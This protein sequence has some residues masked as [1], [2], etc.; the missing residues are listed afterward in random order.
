MPVDT[1]LVALSNTDTGTQR[2]LTAVDLAGQTN[3][4]V[5]LG[6][7]YD[8]ETHRVAGSELNVDSPDELAHRDEAVDA[9]ATTFADAGVTYEIR[10]VFGHDGEGF[11][12]LARQVD[13]DMV[14]VQGGDRT[15]V[16]KAVFGSVPQHILLHAPC[17]VLLVHT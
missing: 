9:V 14:V 12:R 4:H 5:V 2:D 3:A 15:P 16:G 6:V 17:P 11:V 13:A 1:I 10:G 7:S 8:E